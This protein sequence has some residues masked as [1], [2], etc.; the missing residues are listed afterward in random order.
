M[1]TAASQE[2]AV[3]EIVAAVPAEQV[4]M[5]AA[6]A[7]ERFL[8]AMRAREFSDEQLRILRNARIDVDVAPEQLQRAMEEL[9]SEPLND[10]V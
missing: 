1:V 6:V 5:T 4:N 8:A 9:P 7:R 2:A 3:G 10:V